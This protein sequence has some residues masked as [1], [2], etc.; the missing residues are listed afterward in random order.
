MKLR[1]EAT[2]G[3]RGVRRLQPPIGPASDSATNV[4]DGVSYVHTPQRR[5]P[6]IDLG[7]RSSRVTKIEA[8]YRQRIAHTAHATRPADR[9]TPQAAGGVTNQ[10]T[11][12][13]SPLYLGSA[14]QQATREEFRGP[15]T[16][17]RRTVLAARLAAYPRRR[18]FSTSRVEAIYGE[19]GVGPA[20]PSRTLK[21]GA[22]TPSDFDTRP[23][24]AD[25]SSA[26]THTDQQRREHEPAEPDAGH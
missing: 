18:P 25:A 8:A 6:S 26:V 9:T 17:V 15:E 10:E 12:V 2:Y 14:A 21:R 1:L 23:I 4:R 24:Q 22:L 20:Q 3:Q 7:R 13:P 16:G 5:A 19:T 11:R